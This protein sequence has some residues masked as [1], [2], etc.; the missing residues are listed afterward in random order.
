MDLNKF[1]THKTLGFFV[2]TKGAF[3]KLIYGGMGHIFML[4]RVVKKEDE[5]QFP[6]NSGLSLTEE[7][8]ESTIQLYRSQ[9]FEF[10]SMDECYS[11]I[12][13]K[14]KMTKPFVVFTLDDGYADN[15]TRALPI[16]ERNEI[17]FCIYICS[18]FLNQEAILWWY[19]L[20]E[21]ISQ[22][23]EKRS[24]RSNKDKEYY[25]E[26][27]KEMKV[28][29]TSHSVDQT[30]TEL[31]AKAEQNRNLHH[32]FS[33]TRQ[34]LVKASRHPL[35]TIGAHTVTH[36]Q[37]NLLSSEELVL[38]WQENKTEL[39]EICDQEVVHCAY[40]YG[41]KEDVNNK[42][43]EITKKLGFKTAVMNYPGN[44]FSASNSLLLPR[45][46]LGNNFSDKDLKIIQNG[47]RHFS[48]NG[49][50]KKIRL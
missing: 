39:E 22:S 2:K 6:L 1:L 47:I 10:L 30:F 11:R 45:Y 24:G 4:H 26:R 35:L 12:K 18:G 42:V 36:R 49:F 3:S 32:Q 20:E 25:N 15:L 5:F 21:K 13:S 41:G 23:E 44:L 7:A 16:F 19:L 34:D 27:A 31:N 9:G 43:V 8:L 50:S 28:F 33:M 40:P 38:E 17:P 14:K 48:N 29:H 46:P 37:L